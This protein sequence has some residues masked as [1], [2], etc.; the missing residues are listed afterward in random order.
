M[1]VLRATTM[2]MCPGVRSAIRVAQGVTAP[3]L[4][5]IHGEL[6]HNPEINADLTRRGFRSLPEAN[7][8]VIP[9]TP[10]V[11]ITAHGISDRDR[12]RLTQAGRHIIDA[13]CPLVRKA[14][15]S[16]LALQQ[17]GFFVVVIGRPGHVEV[18]GI[19]GDLD[20]F[21]VVESPDTVMHWKHDRIGVVCQTTTPPVVARRVIETIRLRN[22]E[23]RLE[24][25][26]T[27]C[28]P[29]RARQESLDDLLGRVEALVIVGAPGSNNTQQLARL[30]ESRHVRVFLVQN[31]RQ[32]D[33]EALTEFALVG[34][35]A[36][37]SALD[38]SVEEVYRALRRVKTGP[39][40]PVGLARAIFRGCA[41]AH[42]Q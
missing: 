10:G 23:S 30:A 27:I 36:G 20:S 24:V 22:P 29:T 40:T 31:A 3:S 41:E 6:V 5:T 13:T 9:Q 12:T 28:A 1:N 15:Q 11:L 18:N 7:G 4:V 21:A 2:G 25:A 17:A 42:S 14:H 8:D 19:T 26:N 16:A 35:T 38:A 33:I 39:R 32:L 37:A 34:L